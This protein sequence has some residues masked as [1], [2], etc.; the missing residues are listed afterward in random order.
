VTYACFLNEK[1]NDDIE[2]DETKTGDN[3]DFTHDIV[4]SNFMTDKPVSTNDIS[5]EKESPVSFS[6]RLNQDTIFSILPNTIN[7]EEDDF[8]NAKF[9]VEPSEEGDSY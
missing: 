5:T 7:Y 6:N 2:E 9:L 4:Y 3:D 8:D 1:E